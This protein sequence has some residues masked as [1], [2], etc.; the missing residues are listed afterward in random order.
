MANRDILRPAAIDAAAWNALFPNLVA[1]L[2]TT[3]G[4]YLA[5]LDADA[6]YLASVGRTVTD[7]SKLFSFDVQQAIGFSPLVMLASASD[8]QVSAPGSPLSFGRTFGSGIIP[9]NLFG[10]FGWGWSDSWEASV[11]VDPDGTVNVLGP[12]VTVHGLA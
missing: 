9:R 10:R 12:S 2:G 5:R 8:A 6:Q 11:F 3:W 7:V 1:Q 4:Q